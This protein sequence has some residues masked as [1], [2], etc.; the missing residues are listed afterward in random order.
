[1]KNVAVLTGATGGLGKA[2]ICELL[3]ENI[4]EIWAIARNQNKLDALCEQFG[5]K[6]VPVKCDLSIESEVKNLQVLFDEQKPNIV[7]LIN[8]AGIAKMGKIIDFNDDD[9]S[10]TVEINCKAPTL[11]C[12]YAVPY[13]HSGSKI[14]NI[15]SASS[16]QP[17]P[18]IALYS[19]SKVYLRSYSRSLNYELK[20]KGIT[21][22]AV[23]PGWIDTEMLKTEQNGNHVKFPGLV[24]PERVVKKALKDAKKGKDMSV[25]SLFVKY[26]HLCSKIYPQKW[27]MRIWGKAV[28][29]YVKDQ[30]RI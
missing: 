4:D 11:I 17:N 7:F 16:F 6:I 18:Y 15:S 29:K 25:C 10:H 27:L 14:L 19:A 8:N 3:K 13:M 24:S 21:C 9:I 2:F 20:E 30:N 23:C 1:M 5:E 12:Q 22:T 28:E 26:E